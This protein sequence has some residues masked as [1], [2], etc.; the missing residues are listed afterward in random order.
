M[1]L[2]GGNQKDLSANKANDNLPSWGVAPGE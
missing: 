1:D 2:D